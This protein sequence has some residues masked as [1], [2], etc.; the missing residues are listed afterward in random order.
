MQK[1]RFWIEVRD[2]VWILE[3]GWDGVKKENEH[4]CKM[5]MWQSFQVSGFEVSKP[6]QKGGP[7]LLLS[8]P[9]FTFETLKPSATEPHIA[10]IGA[11]A[12][13]GWTALRLQEAGARVT[14]LDAWGPGNSRASSG[15]ETRVMRG[16]YGP[17]QPYTEMAARALKLWAEYERRWKRQLLHRS[18]VLWMAAGRGD[19]FE[20]GSVEMLQL[21]KIA[22]Q[23]LSASEMRKRWPQINFDGI[24][25]GI[26]EPECG[27]LDARA[28]C[29]AVAYAFVAAGGRYRQAAVEAQ[30]L[31]S[32]PLRGLGLSDG[33]ILKADSYVFAC[34]PWLGKL[35]PL[36][37]GNLVQATKQDVFFFGTPA[38]DSRFSDGHMPVWADH[39]D[40]FRYG[41][42]GS[43]RRGFKI[44]DDTRG[45]EFDATNGERVVGSEILKDIR[46]Y[47]GFRFPALRDAPLVET[48]VCQY[49]QTPDSHFIV[50]RH[51]ANKNVWLVGGG[52]GH[53][54]KHGPAVGEM[55]AELILEDREPEAIW[56]LDRFSEVDKTLSS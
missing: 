9:R 45:P 30:G 36:T 46:E 34:G 28:S 6:R 37:I 39:C 43:D 56:R 22:F 51:R 7:H 54:F 55:M 29:D 35:F 33:S 13:G 10:V 2:S 8:S 23:E 27:Y 11:G 18:G 38:G 5:A 12:F 24:E 16:T 26:L 14:L 53:G 52:S 47:V 19:A 31:E 49:E 1:L 41:I 4:G 48:R 42:P 21:A 50:D 20:R 40:R 17:D 44:A 25:W 15:G 3:M 32:S